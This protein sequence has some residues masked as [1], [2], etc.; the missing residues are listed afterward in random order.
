MRTSVILLT[1]ALSACGAE[2]ANVAK[3]FTFPE[4]AMHDDRV[5]GYCATAFFVSPTRLVTAAH[6]FS[7]GTTY[8]YIKVGGQNVAVKILRIDYDRDICVVEAINYSNPTWYP[9]QRNG[10]VKLKGFHLEERTMSEE[11][12]PNRDRNATANPIVEGESGGPLV[13]EAGQV[14]GMGVSGGKHSCVAVSSDAIA[15]FLDEV[16]APETDK[17]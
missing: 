2:D 9:L 12:A 13:N 16:R 14:V 8:H 3:I 6:T 10:I 15:K 17:H 4:S 7:K 1:L 11:V 5:R